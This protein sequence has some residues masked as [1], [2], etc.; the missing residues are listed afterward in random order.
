MISVHG[1]TSLQQTFPFGF[2]GPDKC[3]NRFESFEKSKREFKTRVRHYTKSLFHG[4]KANGERAMFGLTYSPT[5]GRVYCFVC[6]LLSHSQ[7]GLSKDGFDDWRN[8]VLIKNHENS[9]EHRN[10]LLSYL[11]RRKSQTVDTQLVSWSSY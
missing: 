2:E 7:C 1:I 11:S 6:K 10:A 4:S 5:T 3:Q 9:S 8:P